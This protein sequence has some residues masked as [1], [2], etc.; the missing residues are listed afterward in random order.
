MNNRKNVVIVLLAAVVLWMSVWLEV[1]SGKREELELAKGV[2]SHQTQPAA[3]DLEMELRAEATSK[4]TAAQLEEAKQETEVLRK[5][6]AE[7]EAKAA[8]DGKS[9]SALKQKES[10]NLQRQLAQQ[11]AVLEEQEQKL[12]SAAKVIEREQEQAK[13]FQ[14]AKVKLDEALAK[15][16]NAEGRIAQLQEKQDAAAAEAEAL[17]AQVIGLEK[18]V[19]ERGAAFAGAAKELENCRLNSTILIAKI[20]EQSKQEQQGCLAEKVAAREEKGKPAEQPKQQP[21]LQP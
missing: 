4:Q 15:L 1:E 21:V 19:E 8:A 10:D 20:A 9:G 5:R 12:A 3:K 6:N 17:R 16:Q 11:Q 7:L 14:D 13:N 2:G 18:M